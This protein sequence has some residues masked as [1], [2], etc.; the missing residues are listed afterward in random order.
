MMYLTVRGAAQFHQLH[1]LC[2]VAIRL[3]WNPQV[4]NFKLKQVALAM[5]FDI[6][7]GR[8]T[9]MATREKFLTYLA[10]PP[11]FLPPPHQPLQMLAAAAA[12]T[13]PPPPPPPPPPGFTLDQ[14]VAA[15]EEMEASGDP[16]LDE[17]RLPPPP[18]PLGFT[19]TDLI[20]TTMDEM[21]ASDPALAEL[22]QLACVKSQP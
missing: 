18:P 8:T 13:P 15:I 1:L 21:A 2:C 12:A 22:M 17:L 3:A 16:A 5:S 4:A 9:F 6:E 14:A 19:L 10:A 7:K 20:V 11:L